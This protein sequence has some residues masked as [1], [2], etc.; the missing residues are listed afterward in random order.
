MDRMVAPYGT[1]ARLQALVDSIR[2][3]EEN[4]SRQNYSV[5]DELAEEVSTIRM[6]DRKARRT[7]LTCD[8][9]MDDIQLLELELEN[10]RKTLRIT[11]EENIETN[12]SIASYVQMNEELYHEIETLKKRLEELET[13]NAVLR[14]Q[15]EIFQGDF[16]AERT[17][18]DVFAGQQ[19][20]TGAERSRGSRRGG[21]Y[22]TH[23]QSDGEDEIDTEEYRYM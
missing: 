15:S 4:K 10:T 19:Q 6:S 18:S 9:K 22:A 20:Y 11:R 1:L 21:H 7:A 2:I 8:D 13:E 16:D 3:T 23:H 17:S 12:Q 5:D 14:C